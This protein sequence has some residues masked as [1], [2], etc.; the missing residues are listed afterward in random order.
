MPPKLIGRPIVDFLTHRHT[1]QHLDCIDIGKG[2][3]QLLQKK[4]AL[5]FGRNQLTI[6]LK[7]EVKF[8]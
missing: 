5:L 1:L 4:A 7:G 3:R 2:R 8:F 6:K